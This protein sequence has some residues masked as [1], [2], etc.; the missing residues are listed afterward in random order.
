MHIK[1]D[2]V[3][4]C[5]RVR[6][7]ARVSVRVRERVRVCMRVRARVHADEQGGVGGG[8]AVVPVCVCVHT[9]ARLC[10]S[11]NKCVR[12]PKRIHGR[13]PTAGSPARRSV[14]VQSAVL[15]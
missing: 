5:A 12:P 9:H 6:L 8:R 13:V 7:C 1:S 4:A 15:I 2:G 14:V 3:R 11:T 10:T